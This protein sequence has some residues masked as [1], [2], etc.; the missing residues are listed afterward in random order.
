MKITKTHLLSLSIVALTSL[1]IQTAQ[2]TST[3]TGSADLTIAITGISNQSNPGSGYGNDILYSGLLELD[4]FSGSIV[5]GTGNVSPSFSGSPLPFDPIVLPTDFSFNQSM[6]INGS[7]T[8][9]NIDSYYLGLTDILLENES[10][11]TYVI[12]YTVSYNLS[13]VT[14]GEYSEGTMTIIGDNLGLPDDGLGGY[15]EVGSFS[16]TYSESN[17]LALSLTLDGLSSIDFY[18]E[19]EFSGYAEASSVAPVPLPGAIWLFLA[20]LV[21]LPK[22]KNRI[23]VRR[24][25]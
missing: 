19:F 12:D 10:S 7:V 2:A 8:D 25:A 5:D 1:S 14:G 16:D 23:I 18:S 17:T 21:A 9:G 20:G 15:V 4:P 11:D 24:A 13:V 6:L 3:Y 22:Y